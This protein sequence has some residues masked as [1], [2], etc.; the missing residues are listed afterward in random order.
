MW[1]FWLSGFPKYEV[2]RVFFD[3][4][5]LYTGA[6][7]E[8]IKN[9]ARQLAVTFKLTNTVIHVTIIS[10]VSKTLFDQSF[11]QLDDVTDVGGGF[12]LC[13]WLFDTEQL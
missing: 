11:N 7:F 12:W 8:F 5:H 13:V 10:R 4:A 9:L 6:S 1:L 2:E 3:V